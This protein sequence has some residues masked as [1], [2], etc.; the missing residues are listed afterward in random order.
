MGTLVSFGACELLHIEF[1]FALV[2]HDKMFF[3]SIPGFAFDGL[4]FPCL[5]RL[6]IKHVGSVHAFD[7]VLDFCCIGGRNPDVH[8]QF[9]LLVEVPCELGDVGR[10]VPLD[11]ECSSGLLALHH[12][13]DA[14]LAM[15]VHDERFYHLCTVANEIVIEFFDVWCV[16]AFT[17]NLVHNDRVDGFLFPLLLALEVVVGRDACAKGERCVVHKRSGDDERCNEVHSHLRCIAGDKAILVVGEDECEMTVVATPTRCFHR[18]RDFG[19][20]LL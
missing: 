9:L 5:H 4:D 18:S 2:E 14:P 19:N 3:G 13:D 6:V 10:D 16:D 17:N 8:A 20:L 12:C 11:V 7:V 1:F 15:E